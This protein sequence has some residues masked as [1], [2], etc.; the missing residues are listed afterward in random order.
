MINEE[1][2]IDS[3]FSGVD[4]FIVHNWAKL[5]VSLWL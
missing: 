4:I 1:K 5:N 2:F 3:S